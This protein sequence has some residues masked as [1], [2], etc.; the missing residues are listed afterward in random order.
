MSIGCAPGTLLGAGD[1]VVCNRDMA[2]ALLFMHLGVEV[3][4]VGFVSTEV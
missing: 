2:Q 1:P 3:G 4:V